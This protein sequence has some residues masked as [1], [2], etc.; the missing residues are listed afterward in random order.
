SDIMAVQEV[1]FLHTYENQLK[2]K[3]SR[4]IQCF[5]SA[6]T[7]AKINVHKLGTNEG[8]L[9]NVP[10]NQNLWKPRKSS[11]SLTNCTVEQLPSR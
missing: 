8:F 6:K 5:Y 7:L 4:R 10:Y 1:H 2:S 11:V 9:L 3:F